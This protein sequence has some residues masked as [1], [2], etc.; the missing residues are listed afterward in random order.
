MSERMRLGL[1]DLHFRLHQACRA[2]PRSARIVMLACA[3]WGEILLQ[4]LVRL[5]PGLPDR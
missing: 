5:H 3:S 1:E 4:G 2:T